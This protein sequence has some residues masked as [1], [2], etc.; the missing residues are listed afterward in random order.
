VQCQ[1]C[2]IIYTAIHIFVIGDCGR[3]LVHV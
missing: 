1:S 3:C 2:G